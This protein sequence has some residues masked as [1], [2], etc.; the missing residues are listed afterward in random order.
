MSASSI[1][2][3]VISRTAITLAVLSALSLAAVL[4]LYF[5]E[6]S[7]PP[8]IMAFGVFGLPLAFILAGVVII[9]NIRKRR[10]G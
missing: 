9:G 4:V 10:N 1:T 5:K 8:I 3:T 7:I 6:I 2:L